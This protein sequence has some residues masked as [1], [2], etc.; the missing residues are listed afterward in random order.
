LKNVWKRVAAATHRQIFG[1]QLIKSF[2]SGQGQSNLGH[3]GTNG[4]QQIY[5]NIRLFSVTGIM[6]VDLNNN[7]QSNPVQWY[8]QATNETDT[9]IMTWAPEGNFENYSNQQAAI[10]THAYP[11][12][13]STLQWVA[14]KMLLYNPTNAPGKYSIELISLKDE[15]LHPVS[16]TTAGAFSTAFWQYM[17]KKYSFNP[18][19]SADTTWSKYYKVHK[20]LV[21]NMDSKDTDQTTNTNYKEVNFFA[22]LN[23]SLDY[24]WAQEDRMNMI[25]N[26]TQINMSR[27]LTDVHPR[28]RMYILVRALAQR[29]TAMNA[30]VHP[31][32]DYSLKVCHAV[33]D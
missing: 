6:N 28:R 24:A 12:A 30:A 33:M 7:V 31:S 13:K 3:W 26:E 22:R 8:L 23:K 1:Q 15:R 9:S 11:L 17:S 19:A 20:R 16:P 10:Q 27:N 5:G 21:I 32:F 4:A 29:D 18:I 14:F 2:G 25:N